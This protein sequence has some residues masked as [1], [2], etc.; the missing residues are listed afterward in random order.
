MTK[1]Q[2]WANAI[3][4]VVQIDLLNIGLPQFVKKEKKK[5]NKRNIFDMQ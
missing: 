1:G 3:G 2:T 5:K 4:K